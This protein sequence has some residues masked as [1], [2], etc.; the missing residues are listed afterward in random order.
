[1]SG[2]GY[3]KGID[4]GKGTDNNNAKVTPEAVQEIRRA[5]ASLGGM[6]RVSGSHPCSLRSL[7]DRF[8]IKP[9]QVSKISLGRQWEHVS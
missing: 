6:R 9:S 2:K 5:R 3:P 4:H 1:M 7:A 8:G